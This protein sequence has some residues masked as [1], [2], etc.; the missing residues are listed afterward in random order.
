MGIIGLIHR[1]RLYRVNKN[2][3]NT[4]MSVGDRFINNSLK[5][6]VNTN[7]Y[8]GDDVSFNGM[9]IIGEGKVSIGDHFHCAEGCYIICENHDF[10]HGRELPY[11]HE[12]SIP[13]E[14]LIES[15]VWLGVNVI[16]L[17]GVHIA[18]GAIIQAGSV[19]IGDIPKC[20]I[21]G[22]H[23]AKVFRYRDINHYEKLKSKKAFVINKA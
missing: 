15:N 9:R 3:M 2:I 18:E 6:C 19:V 21:A 16:I 11:D 13:K 5:S 14:V 20:G 4:A 10:D 8:I 23:P 22:G 1:V 12:R 7:T 17:P